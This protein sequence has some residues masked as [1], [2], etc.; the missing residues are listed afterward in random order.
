MDG[1]SSP[2]EIF[3]WALSVCSTMVVPERGKPTMKIGWATSARTLAR[4]RRFSR[5]VV[6]NALS[7]SA[8]VRA[9]SAM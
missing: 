4:G 2:A 8:S 9:A 1:S 6:K 7:R 3:G 5:P